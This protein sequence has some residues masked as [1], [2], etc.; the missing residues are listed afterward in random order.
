MLCPEIA[1]AREQA[2]VG[3]KLSTSL[4]PDPPGTHPSTGHHSGPRGQPPPGAPPSSGRQNSSPPGPLGGGA[5]QPSGTPGSGLP[6]PPPRDDAGDDAG[7]AAAGVDGPI[8]A[9]GDG[10]RD[11]EGDDASGPEQDEDPVMALMKRYAEKYNESVDAIRALVWQP[12]KWTLEELKRLLDAVFLHRHTGD[13]QDDEL[14]EEERPLSLGGDGERSPEGCQKLVTVYRK[15]LTENVWVQVTN[16]PDVFSYI[17]EGEQVDVRTK[18]WNDKIGRVVRIPIPG[19][20]LKQ[21]PLV[22]HGASF[23]VEVEFVNESDEDESTVQMPVRYIP[24]TNLIALADDQVPQ[25]LRSKWSEITQLSPLPKPR[26]QPSGERPREV[27]PKSGSVGAGDGQRRTGIWTLDDL[28]SEKGGDRADKPSV[29]T[30]HFPPAVNQSKPAWNFSVPLGRHAG[31]LGVHPA[32]S[33]P[34]DDQLA[35]VR[36]DQKR[37]CEEARAKQNQHRKY[38]ED[39]AK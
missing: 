22:P 39:K 2:R 32:Y 29:A 16:L 3:E 28:N 9:G 25:S 19:E 33:G 38:E 12:E 36:A 6:P 17:L 34:L 13:E 35:Q 11:Y 37:K 21:A 5:S 23:W 1:Q 7:G 8:L 14:V 30:K 27:A 18:E 26:R 4:N 15:R 10:P 24:D 20:Q 31:P